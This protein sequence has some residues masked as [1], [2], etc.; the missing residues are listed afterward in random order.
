MTEWNEKLRKMTAVEHVLRRPDL[1]VGSMELTQLTHWSLGEQMELRSA[2]FNAA[3]YKIVDEILVNAM[4]QATRCATEKKKHQVHQITVDALEPVGLSVA[5]DGKGIP[6]EIHQEYQQYHHELVFGELRTSTNFDDEEKR[7]VGGRNGL[8]C[9]LTNILSERFVVTGVDAARRRSIRLTFEDH[10]SQKQVDVVDVQRD[11]ANAARDSTEVAFVPSHVFPD[12]DA[13]WNAMLPFLKRRVQDVAV[14]HP[15]V[16]VTWCGQQMPKWSFTEY[17]SQCVRSLD[18]N[19]VVVGWDMKVS[20]SAHQVVWQVA[21]TW[22]E[23]DHDWPS[24]SFVNGVWTQQHGTHVDAIKAAC[25]QV[26][27]DACK[28]TDIKKTWIKDHLVLFVNAVVENPSFESQSKLQLVT[29]VAV[30]P[31]TS[32]QQKQLLSTGIVEALLQRC[33]AKPVATRLARGTISDIDHLLDAPLAGSK[34]AEQCILFLVEGLSARTS[35]LAGFAALDAHVRKRCGVF[36]LKGKVLNVRGLKPKDWEQNAEVQ[37]LKRILGVPF[38]GD[39]KPRY[40]R[41]VFFT[42]QDLDGYHIRGLLLNLF[43][44]CW[45][46]LIKPGFLLSFRTPIVKVLRQG[47]IVLQCFDAEEFERSKALIRPSDQI[48]YYKGLGTSDKSEA[49][50]YFSE[51]AH[52][53]ITFSFD[54]RGAESLHLAF[55]KDESDQRKTWLMDPKQETPPLRSVGP[56]AELNAH[57]ALGLELRW[58]QD[59]SEF[60]HH[61]LV[62]FARYNVMRS[63]PHLMD[64]LKVSQRKILY[65]CLQRNVVK[66]TKVL[67][68]A[69]D[70][71]ADTAYHH[72]DSS[73]HDTI[74][75]M[76]QDFVGALNLPLLVPCG[77]FGSRLDGGDDSA[78]A[79][80]VFTKLQPYTRLLFRPEDDALLPSQDDDGKPIEP[81]WYCP[82]IPVLLCNGCNGIATG[83]STSVPSYHPLQ[84]IQYLRHR[85]RPESDER[86]SLEPSLVPWYKGFR[87]T[88]TCSDQECKLLGRAMLVSRKPCRV[89]IDELPPHTWVSAYQKQLQQWID[90]N[91]D[92]KKTPEQQLRGALRSF[93]SSSQLDQI[94]F[95]LTFDDASADLVSES[96]ESGAFFKTFKLIENV[97]FKNMHGFDEHLKVIHLESIEQYLS[98]FMDRRIEVY[99][100]RKHRLLHELRQRVARNQLRWTFVQDMLHKLLPIWGVKHDLALAMMRDRYASH[101]SSLTALGLDWL[102]LLDAMLRTPLHQFT[103]EKVQELQRECQSAEETRRRLEEETAVTLWLR[104]LDELEPLLRSMDQ[105]ESEKHQDHKTAEEPQKK[106]RQVRAK[107]PR[108]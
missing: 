39:G 99:E 88:V 107:R 19:R 78:S 94:C 48:K 41:V 27:M 7:I 74:K 46:A 35:C 32:A 76:A 85:L 104:D 101:E 63:V 70:V 56:H 68:L 49:M 13:V 15:Q 36:A 28:K 2:P 5:N 20:L 14:L 82:V 37:H 62:Q 79:R 95:E 53:L 86:K 90:S 12:R 54:E 64:G 22:K 61:D 24:L 30:P 57:P 42:D 105:T 69:G 45:P 58:Q 84:L 73:L 93:V 77:Q 33:G 52:H 102:E 38:L 59:V 18:P 66:D 25:T 71:M 60:V 108:I 83:F 40:G 96:I 43:E 17:A 92:K 3:L 50:Q 55:H 4:D 91:L 67:T 29:K 97:S 72:G 65:T 51:L 89:R 98:W 9:K 8:G 23:A 26:I 11:S 6:V 31:L 10:M 103:E 47:R 44:Q 100:Q 106:R 21:A 81:Q 80:Y 1:Y 34:D 75:G 87:G 16:D